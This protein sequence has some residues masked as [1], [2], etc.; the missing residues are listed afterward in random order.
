[1]GFNQSEYSVDEDDGLVTVVLILSNPLSTNITVL[2]KD[3]DGSATGI[4]IQYS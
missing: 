3:S 2:V 1:M 4:N